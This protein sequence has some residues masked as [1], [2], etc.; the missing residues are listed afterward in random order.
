MHV[1]NFKF[2]YQQI[3]SPPPQRQQIYMERLCISYQWYGQSSVYY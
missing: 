1:T 2:S 3:K